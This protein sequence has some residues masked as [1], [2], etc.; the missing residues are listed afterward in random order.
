MDDSANILYYFP[1]IAFLVQ[2]LAILY[3]YIPSQS[4]LLEG[5]EFNRL[6]YPEPLHT[7]LY[8]IVSD[9]YKAFRT[10]NYSINTIQAT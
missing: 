10:V 4:L 6:K 2:E 5:K 1:R 7:S 3:A 9:I 8:H